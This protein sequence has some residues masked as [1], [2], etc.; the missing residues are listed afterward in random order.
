MPLHEPVIQFHEEHLVSCDFSLSISYS[1]VFL[2]LTVTSWKSLT[3]TLSAYSTKVYSFQNTKLKG[4]PFHE[5]SN[6][7][8]TPSLSYLQTRTYIIIDQAFPIMSLEM[9]A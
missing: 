4:C 7:E 1:N 2:Q 9:K 8:I 3:A 5:L 6:E